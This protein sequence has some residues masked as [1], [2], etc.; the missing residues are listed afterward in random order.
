MATNT[1]GSRD[2][3]LVVADHLARVSFEDLPETTIA[4]A[5]AAI[6]DAIACMYAGTDNGDVR[7]ITDL[8]AGWG[9][10]PASTV[11][12]TRQRT[13]P[14]HAVF[15]NASASHQND[16][17]DIHEGAMCHPTSSA[18]V[19]A[20]ALAEQRG[21]VS[22]RE[23]IVCVA[24]ASDLVIRLGL[25]V[26]GGFS[27]YPWIRAPIMAQ[28]GAAAASAKML[29]ADAG[30][31]ANALGL[32]LPQVGGTF[33]SLQHPGSGVRGMRDGFVCR[34]GLQAAT[35]AMHG[36]QGDRETF[37]GPFGLFA[38]FFR[39]EYVREQI[40]DDLGKRF[41][42]TDLTFK[43]W[44]CCRHIHAPLT[45]LQGVLVEHQL[46]FEDVHH[47]TV[48]VGDM[49]RARCSPVQSGMIPAN[50]IDLMCNIQFI[51]GAFLRYG[52]VPLDIYSSPSLAN[53]VI[54]SAVPKVHWIH[55]EAQNRRGPF[56]A[57]L[58]DV[59]TYDGKII[60]GRASYGL[61]HPSNPMSTE[62]LR[63]KLIA[64]ARAS[65][66]RINS[67]QANLLFDGIMN[68]EEL[69]MDAIIRLL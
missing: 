27:S 46:D 10:V 33:A 31:H 20:L 8:V 59:V 63:G 62:L 21:G 52:T 44:P 55:D 60:V 45:A 23:F 58:V 32:V 67:E 57:G 2:S 4:V 28:F 48:H 53:D 42:L 14:D 5:K 3:A 16:F 54:E 43:P 26:T 36:V 6:V 15:A 7:A 9:G 68:I 34:N 37:D 29:R 13:S 64:C 56:E 41:H 11:I 1:P 25:S 47:V 17:D 35:L 39:R 50:R 51:V 66:R 12:A 61:G 19:P 69:P 18:V 24:A 49:N 22:G 38:T 30:Q 65:S 40:V